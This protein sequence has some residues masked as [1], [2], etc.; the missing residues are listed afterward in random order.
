MIFEYALEPEMVAAWGDRNNHRFFLRE[1]GPGQGRLV[2]RYPK[3]WARKVWE[4][5]G[6]GSDMDRKRLEELLA[7]LQDTMIK[8]RDYVWDDAETWLDNALAEHN[9]HPFK[10]VL[11]RNNPAYH[12][13]ILC[14]DDLPSPAWETPHG[15]TVKRKTTDMTAVIET[16]LGRCCWVKFIDPYFVKGKRGHKK[17]L[18]A[19]LKVLASDRPVAS[20]ERIEIHTSGDGATADFLRNFY[21]DIIPKGL[22]ITLFQWQEKP[23]GQRL[24]NRYILTDLG[25]VSFQHGLDTGAVGETDDI[26][27][28]DLEQFELRCKQYDSATSTF[29]QAE[30]P[31]KITGTF[32]EWK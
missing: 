19:F 17:S 15:V 13:D 23:G 20:L 11:A 7:R 10:A 21:E 5:F 14:E 4:S 22:Q 25:G 18:Q 31:L 26:N 6:G 29:D 2:S 32:R 8:R 12:P 28:L 3:R 24:H 27:R 30:E 9:R 1:F 16:M